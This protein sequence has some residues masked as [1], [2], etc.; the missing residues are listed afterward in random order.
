MQ[1]TASTNN[2]LR[3]KDPKTSQGF[4]TLAHS[5]IF[6]DKKVDSNQVIKYKPSYGKFYKPITIQKYDT[7]KKII[8]RNVKFEKCG[9][10]V[11]HINLFLVPHQMET[12]QT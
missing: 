10:V 6:G 3:K 5:L 7:Y 2:P 9:L 12:C 1:F 4:K 8:N 11:D